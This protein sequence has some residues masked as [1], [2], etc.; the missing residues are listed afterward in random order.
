MSDRTDSGSRFHNIQQVSAE[1]LRQIA[2]AVNGIRYGSVEI[3][4]HDSKVVQIER[5]EKLRFQNRE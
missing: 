3:I 5:K 1:L 4:V 2:Q